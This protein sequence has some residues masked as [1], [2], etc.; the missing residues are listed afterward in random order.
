MNPTLVWRDFTLVEKS[1]PSSRQSREAFL[2]SSDEYESDKIYPESE[3]ETLVESSSEPDE[4]LTSAAREDPPTRRKERSLPTSD[5][6]SIKKRP[7]ISHSP[8]MNRESSRKTSTPGN[9]PSAISSSRSNVIKKLNSGSRLGFSDSGTSA[10]LDIV[11]GN[12][13]Q[14]QNHE[15][16]L[17]A[18]GEI[19]NTLGEVLYRLNK[20]DSRMDSLEQK[21]AKEVEKLVEQ[22]LEQSKLPATPSSSGCSDTPKKAIKSVV[23]VSDCLS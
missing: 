3:G 17:E 2:E 20:Q 18:L 13:Q 22:R 15:A 10:S 23:R 8:A 16:V 9:T 21:V 19:T 12:V 1:M 14:G 4:S 5:D 11:D 7:R 6:H